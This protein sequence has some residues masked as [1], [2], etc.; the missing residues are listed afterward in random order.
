MRVAVLTNSL[1]PQTLGGAGR[2]ALIQAEYLHKAGHEVRIFL[3]E[4]YGGHFDGLEI[5]TF[6]PHTVTGYH[7]LSVK[8]IFSRLIFHWQDL[9]ANM[10]AADRIIA[11]KPQVIISHNLTGCG[12]KTPAMVQ[13]AGAKWIHIL[14]DVQLFEPSGQIKITETQK[15]VRQHW[16]RFWTRLR[17]KSLGRP[18]AIV[19]PS[20]WL[21]QLHRQYGLD[22][23]NSKVI[24]NPAVLPDTA[25]RQNITD[26]PVALYVGR[27][28]EDKGI[29]LLINA[30]QKNN[31]RPGVLKI[32]GNGPLQSWL[33]NLDDESVQCLGPLSSQEVGD[34]MYSGNLLIFPS[35]IM[36]NQPT[37]L[38][39]AVAAG[40]N[41]IASDTGGVAEMLGDYGQIINLTG[42]DSA[43]KLALAIKTQINRPLN[44]QLREQILKHHDLDR[45]M[46]EYLDVITLQC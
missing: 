34:M 33:N 27:L 13:M 2:I 25:L 5:Q 19:S 42:T 46:Q 36:E 8:S 14:H 18:D 12:W 41:V 3:P 21:L 23:A 7:N 38:L 43:E 22:I 1:P 29:K 17:L 39:E 32:V 24:P 15:F 35:L 4:P 11:W 37:V 16:R 26:T 20:N 31:P 28:S 40:L 44:M 45:I 9:S 6:K 10:R 30:W